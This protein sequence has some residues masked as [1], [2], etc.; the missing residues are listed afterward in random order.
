MGYRSLYDLSHG[1]IHKAA[2]NPINY[3]KLLDV[4]QDKAEN[5]Y[6]FLECLT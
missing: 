6:Q 2:L 4:V 1:G 3:E 5:P